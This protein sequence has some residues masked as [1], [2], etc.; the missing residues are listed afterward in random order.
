MDTNVLIIGAGL[1]G[2]RAAREIQAAGK[3]VTLLEKSTSSGGRLATRRIGEGRAD[4]GAQFF[5][6]RTETFKQQVQEWL[7]ADIVY[8]WSH[9]W[10]DGSLKRTV[11]DGHPR[12]VTKGGMNELAK[13][14]EQGLDVRTGVKVI[15]VERPSHAWQVTDDQGNV[16]S[17]EVLIMTPPPPQSLELLVQIPLTSRDESDLQRLHYGPCLAGMFVVDGELSLPEPGAVQN[18]QQSVYWIADNQ[19]KGISPEERV[20]TL[21]AEA[22]F[23]RQHYDDPEDVTLGLMREALQPYLSENTTIKDAQLKKWRYSVPLTTHP[24]DVLVAEGLPLIFAGDAFGGRGRV[25]GAYL[26]GLAAGNAALEL[27]SEGTG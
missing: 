5:T 17:S 8:V 12:Y 26:S 10:S 27:L 13:H 9:G 2:L 11:G 4:H 3:S 16:Y 20:V 15:A 23:S 7:D 21:H 6:A 18:F 19:A 24:R 14:L 25:E 1:S 22:R